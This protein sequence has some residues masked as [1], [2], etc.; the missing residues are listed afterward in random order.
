MLRRIT[1]R[2]NVTSRT[3]S[4]VERRYPDEAV[5]FSTAVTVL[6]TCRES[7][8]GWSPRRILQRRGNVAITNARIFIQSNFIS[9]LTAIWAA[10][11]VYCLY[12]FSQT[13][14][15]IFVGVAIAAAIFIF[16][17]RPYLR[18]LPTEAIQHVHFGAVRG[19]AARCDIVSI[20][21]E[22]GAIQLVTAQRIPEEIRERLVAI[23]GR[24]V[25][26]D[27]R[28]TKSSAD[29]G[30]GIVYLREDRKGDRRW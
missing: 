17:R 11:I 30:A 25:P 3:R 5:L 18:D 8:T 13:D 4:A 26:D 12:Q 6:E 21:V 15:P 27:G 14:N 19:L 1:D 24:P 22:G 10:A 9:M 23:G 16:Q 2:L 28:K 20:V 7:P 29:A